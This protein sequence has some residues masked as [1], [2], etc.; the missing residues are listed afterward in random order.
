M[1]QE[2]KEGLI[3]D[4]LKTL[5]LQFGSELVEKIFHSKKEEVTTLGDPPHTCLPGYYWDET[6]KKCVKDV[7]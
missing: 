6:S 4:L 7:G 2:Q 1:Q 5:I 3:G